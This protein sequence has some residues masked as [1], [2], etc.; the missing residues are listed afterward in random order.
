MLSARYDAGSLAW[1][2]AEISRSLS[3][4]PGR[5]DRDQPS[6]PGDSLRQAFRG[7]S[8]VTIVDESYATSV[9]AAANWAL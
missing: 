2:S 7:D 8:V 1:Q 3:G 4:S 6:A 9:A 5:T